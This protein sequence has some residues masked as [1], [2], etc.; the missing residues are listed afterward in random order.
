VLTLVRPFP[1]DPETRLVLRDN[2]GDE[3]EFGDPRPDP[4]ECQVEALTAAALDG[5]PLPVPL[6]SSR[7][8][9]ATLTALYESARRG[10]PV[11]L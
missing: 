2:N 11:K 10:G 6:S 9:V 4:Y 3:Q 8:N 1:V 7:G 5:S